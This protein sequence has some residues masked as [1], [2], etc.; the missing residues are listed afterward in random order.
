MSRR[1]AVNDGI[2]LMHSTIFIIFDNW[3]RAADSLSL[4]TDS[5]NC[6]A[7]S[8][9]FLSFADPDPSLFVRASCMMP[10][11]RKS[12]AISPLAHRPSL[13]SRIAVCLVS[14][15]CGLWRRSCWKTAAIVKACF[16]YEPVSPNQSRNRASSATNRRP[17]LP[18]GMRKAFGEKCTHFS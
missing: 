7:E 12:S 5:A 9:G 11:S 17:T 1:C 18:H 10:N 14:S 4:L 15:P 8:A 6:L 2:Q 13:R 3:R 16:E